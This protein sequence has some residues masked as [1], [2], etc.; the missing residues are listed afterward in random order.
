MKGSI[1]SPWYTNRA[2]PF[3][4]TRRI[5]SPSISNEM[6]KTA[7]DRV[8]NATG[9]YTSPASAPS[10]AEATQPVP[11]ASVSPSTPRS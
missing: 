8:R 10:A 9:G 3:S 4:R 1:S 11:H 7:P 2:S 6:T 5:V